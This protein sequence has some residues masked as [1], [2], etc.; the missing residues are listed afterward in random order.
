MPMMPRRPAWLP[1][2]LLMWWMACPM[3]GAQSV[4]RLLPESLALPTYSAEDAQ[5][6]LDEAE[7]KEILRQTVEKAVK[8]ALAPLLADLAGERTRAA[9]WEAQ[10]RAKATEALIAEI[11]AVILA[12]LAAAGW[13]VAVLIH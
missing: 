5:D 3:A 1:C 2:L 7:A 11:A 6:A 10:A 13:G 9:G 12:V 8:V 4:T